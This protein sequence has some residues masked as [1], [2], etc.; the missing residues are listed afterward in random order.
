MAVE[1]TSTPGIS[2][3]K[4]VEKKSPAAADGRAE[5]NNPV[6]DIVGRYVAGKDRR[7]ADRSDRAP[8]AIECHGQG[9]ID[10][11]RYRT[12]TQRQTVGLDHGLLSDGQRGDAERK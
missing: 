11:G 1:I 2:R 8:W 9:M 3:S 4:G 7:R 12:L 6:S 5:N 10:V